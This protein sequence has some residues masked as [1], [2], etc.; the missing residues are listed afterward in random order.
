MRGHN[1]RSI[2]IRC[3]CS[4][5]FGHRQQQKQ[6]FKQFLGRSALPSVA[7]KS[8]I[9]IR[10][11]IQLLKIGQSRPLFVYV[12]LFKQTSLHFL[13]QIDMKKYPSSIQ[14]RDSNPRTSEH[15]SPPITTR[16]GL[17]HY[18]QQS[19]MIAVDDNFVIV[20]KQKIKQL[21]KRQ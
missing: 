17:F 7:D 1:E 5:V 8:I 16:P 18:L 2:L 12:C 9:E 11:N 19:M 3:L 6:Q 21:V 15:E 13:Q 20:L 4:Q 10:P 14:R